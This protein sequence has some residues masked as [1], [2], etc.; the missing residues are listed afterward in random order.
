M[1]PTLVKPHAVTG[2]PGALGPRAGPGR[3]P[4]AARPRIG[5]R[6]AARWAGIRPGLTALDVVVSA[7]HGQLL[8]WRRPYTDADWA[9]AQ[10][11]LERLGASA[12]SDRSIHIALRGPLT[13]SAFPTVLGDTR[14]RR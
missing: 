4:R 12:L 2:C 13:Y 7:V 14:P 8:P 10:A 11:Q 9:R 3:R 1:A 5:Y 6:G